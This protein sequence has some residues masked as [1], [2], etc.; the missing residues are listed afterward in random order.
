MS[1]IFSKMVDFIMNNRKILPAWASIALEKIARNPDGFWGKIINS[2]LYSENDYTLTPVP[3]KEIRLYISPTNYAGQA[4]EWARAAESAST[5]I[6]AQNLE[7]VIPGGYGFN[8]GG[9]VALPTFNKS[10]EWAERE[11]NRAIKFSHVLVE[12]ERPMFGRKFRLNLESEISDLMSRDISVAFICHGTDIRD[13][14]LH[15]ALTSWSPYQED[16]RTKF[17][18]KDVIQNKALLKKM[19]LPTFVSTPDLLID[20]P[21]AKWCPVVVQV[22][23]FK[24]KRPVFSNDLPLVVHVSSNPLQKGT[25][26]IEPTLEKLKSMGLIDFEII[27]SMNSKDIPALFD[28]ADIVLDQF[29]SG[30]FGTAACEAMAAERVVIGHVVPKVREIVQLETGLRL[31]IVEANPNSLEKVL[32]EVLEN[33]QKYSRIALEGREYVIQVHSG[34]YSAQQLINEWILER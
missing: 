18:R 25:L 30:A 33:K 12:A 23:K 14:D 34:K 6:G 21:E 13:P 32:R 5:K 2:L 20:L 24:S 27:T 22:Q 4:Y 3:K 8:S 10:L 26:L 28:K 1:S 31:P 29:R 17:L 9:K 19:S 7:I 15:S 11:F 16:P